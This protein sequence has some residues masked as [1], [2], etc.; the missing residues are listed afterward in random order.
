[1]LRGRVR[2][3]VN[4]IT[5]F[6]TMTMEGALLKIS[7]VD[8]ELT[9]PAGRPFDVRLKVG[10]VTKLAAPA[11]V[12]LGL[13]GALAGKLRAEPATVPVGKEEA[14]LRIIPTVALTGIH[15]FTIRATALQDGK[16]PAISQTSVTVVL[17]SPGK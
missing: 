14:V 12:E 17:L 3:Q 10:R 5:G 13:P 16:Y 11:H 15:T 9:V 4:E 6:V 8:P 1:D 7:A 2:Y